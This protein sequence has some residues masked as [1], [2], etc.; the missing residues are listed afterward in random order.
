MKSK[1]KSKKGSTPRTRTKIRTSIMELM[2]E[3]ANLTHDDNLAVGVMKSIFGSYRV[4]LAGAPV[5]LRLEGAADMPRVFRKRNGGI[6]LRF[7]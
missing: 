2:Q 6:S 1:H 3:L 5:A 4:R 7:D